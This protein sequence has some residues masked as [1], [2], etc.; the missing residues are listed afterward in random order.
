MQ[1]RKTY[2]VYRRLRRNGKRF[3]RI[4]LKNKP[5]DILLNWVD[6][7]YRLFRFMEEKVYADIMTKP[8]GSIDAFVQMANEVLNRRKS[9]AGKSLEHHLADIFTK[10]ELVFEE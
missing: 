9:R 2:S 3:V 6:T 5:D 4:A 10:N 1:R 8:F 7:E